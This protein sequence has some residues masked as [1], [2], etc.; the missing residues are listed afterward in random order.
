MDAAMAVMAALID[1]N[2]TGHG[3]QVDVAMVESMTRFMTPRIISYLGSGE[4]PRRS[5]GKDSVIAIYQT[6]HTA[7]HPMTLGLGN[8]AIWKRFCKAVGRDDMADNPRFANYTGRRADRAEIV[9]ALQEILITKT[10]GQWLELFASARIPA[11]PINSL[12][13]VVTDP[14]LT[15]RGLFYAAHRNGVA[16]PQ[17]G[18]GIRID[19][20]FN[21]YR[22]DPPRLGEDTR[23]AFA[24][25]LG[26][27][28]EAIQK[29]D[30]AGLL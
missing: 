5:G 12:D 1:R 28:D 9:Q 15:E 27:N 14:I 24:S 16:V 11:G 22:K 3:H 19:G 10:R 8:D 13:Q 4:L 7:D 18:L 26:W 2:H 6:F 23:N 30:D 20:N 17:V 21:T 29:L 25:W